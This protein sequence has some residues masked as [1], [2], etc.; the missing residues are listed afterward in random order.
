MN[1]WKWAS[2][3]AEWDPIK[4]GKYIDESGAHSI[5][6]IIE[7]SKDIPVEE[8]SVS[9]VLMFNRDTHTKEGNLE[10]QIRN[11]SEKFKE[12]ANRADLSYPILISVE[13]WIIDGAHRLAKAYWSGIKTIKAKTIDIELL[14]AKERW[15]K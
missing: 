10:E 15:Q 2:N 14:K 8:I 12:R 7:K 3:D 5:K 1:W 13:G 4:D 6:W 11:P 9:S